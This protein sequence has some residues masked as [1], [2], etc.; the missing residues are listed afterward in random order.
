M[1]FVIH[2]AILHRYGMV[3]RR[4]LKD[5]DDAWRDN[6]NIGV[7]GQVVVL[8][9]KLRIVVAFDVCAVRWIGECESRLLSQQLAEG[10]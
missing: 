9:I 7:V 8:P 5:A 10:V 3:V 6:D 2:A 4:E 1:P